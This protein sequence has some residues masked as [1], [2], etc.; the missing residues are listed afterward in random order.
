MSSA[1]M[2]AMVCKAFGP[3]TTLSLEQVPAPTPGR[4]DVVV[5]T[6]AVGINFTDLLAVEGRSQLKRLPPIIPGTEVA[7]EIIRV[8]QDVSRFRIGQRV[9]G[10]CVH[11]AYAEQALLTEDEVYPIPDEMDFES[12]ASFYI[13]STTSRYALV[14]RARLRSGENLLVLGAGSGAGLA[15]I[16]IGK[17][18]GSRVI[19][20]AS[21]PEKLALALEHGADGTVLYSPDPLDTDGQ[22]KFYA[23]LLAASGRAN[24]PSAVSLGKLSSVSGA[25]GFDVIYDAVGGTYTEPALRSLAWEGRYLSVG[26]AAG[27]SA[28]SLGPLLF[29]NAVLMG[30]Q[31]AADDAR[32][33]GR[34]VAAMEQMLGWFRD[35]LLRP[36]ITELYPL[37]RAGEALQQLKDRRA[38]GRIVLKVT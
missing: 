35:G 7:G 25:A 21:S 30:I 14:E 5:R 24:K 15:A 18:L 36:R 17:A 12:A 9:L 10:T 32:L 28:P 11:G 38:K 3:P 8:G 20:A 4:N 26:F 22:K 27:V 31:P 16:Q 2:R 37:E 6:H 1:T 23:E 34:N 33:P 13:A 29:K 19:G